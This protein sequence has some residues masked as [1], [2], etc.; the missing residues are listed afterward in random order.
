MNRKLILHTVKR[1][2]RLLYFDFGLAVVLGILIGYFPDYTVASSLYEN[3]V[4]V[5]I[6]AAGSLLAFSFVG[7]SVMI[8]IL[9]DDDFLLFL[10]QEHPD[11]TI[12]AIWPFWFLSVLVFTALVLG[13]GSIALVPA[14]CIL[15]KK[16]TV[17]FVSFFFVWA[18]T[19]IPVLISFVGGML[20]LR[21]RHRELA[22]SG[23]DEETTQSENEVD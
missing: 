12:G 17:G 19:Y 8:A 3:L 18:V 5:Q 7:T 11:G 9:K 4:G 23:R 20:D 10:H 2:K 13:V 6:A 22:S 1:R 14:S 16:I 15:A 21:A